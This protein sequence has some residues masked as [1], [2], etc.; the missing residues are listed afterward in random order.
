MIK[1]LGSEKI[2]SVL[3]MFKGEPGTW[4]SSSAITF[5]TPQFWFSQ[6]GKMNSVMKPAR[7]HGVDISQVEYEEYKTWTEME[8]KVESLQLNCKYKTLIIDSVTTVGDTVNFETLGI[9]SKD[10]KG[11]K[12]GGI[13]VNS[14]EDYNAQAAAFTSLL[15][16]MKDIRA[17]HNTNIILIAHVVGER[18]ITE[19]SVTNAA[20]TIVTGGKAISG[21]I[22]AYCD[23]IYHFD[24]VPNPVEGAMPDFQIFTV[25]TGFDFARTA[26]SLPTRFLISPNKN[27]W[28]DFVEPAI[29]QM[30]SEGTK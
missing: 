8:R 9:K 3:A 24:V 26:L 14:I 4:K 25:P 6:D 10:D 7:L 20:R 19:K 23:E 18:V 29:T 28:K 22:P 2:Q 21:K 11:K 16:R 13:R 1:T 15:S 17:F 12:I 30:N 27:L 5:P